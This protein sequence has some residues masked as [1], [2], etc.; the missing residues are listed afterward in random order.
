MSALIVSRIFFA[1]DIPDK[2]KEDIGQFITLM[3]K[4]AKWNGIRWTKTE[5]LHITLQFLAEV[6]NHHL[7]ELIE[8]VRFEIENRVPTT[9]FEIKAIE[10]LPSPFRPRVIVFSIKDQE[11]LEKLSILIG[12]GIQ[13]ANY[14]I[15]ERSYKAHMTL[16]RIKHIQNPH[17]EF[18][19]ECEMP[20][21]DKIPLNEV[22]LFRSDPQPD[23]TVYTPLKRIKLKR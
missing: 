9:E 12:Q 20:Q 17:L 11:A 23:G 19:D 13:S 3:K 4:K 18:L 7:P 15:E 8:R 6:Q 10:L 5:N 21:L 1:I 14:P 16:G 22:V 2:I